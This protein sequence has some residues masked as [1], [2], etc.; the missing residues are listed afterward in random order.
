MEYTDTQNRIFSLH[1]RA[2]LD[3]TQEIIDVMGDLG[4]LQKIRIA[5][6]IANIAQEMFNAGVA[7]ATIA[8]AS[9]TFPPEQFDQ[10]VNLFMKG[11][12]S[13]KD[14]DEFVEKIKD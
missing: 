12:V 2:M 7:G 6:C 9:E 1:E 14:F 3:Y 5:Q 10:L 4:K 8:F 13:S 11:N